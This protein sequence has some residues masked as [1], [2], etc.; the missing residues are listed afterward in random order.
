MKS[1]RSDN[2]PQQ[3]ALFIE[4]MQ[5]G[6]KYG[7][8]LD[9]KIGRERVEERVWREG[10]KRGKIEKVELFFKKLVGCK[11]DFWKL[12]S[13]D[14]AC[15]FCKEM[16]NLKFEQTCLIRSLIAGFQCSFGGV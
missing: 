15:M 16:K 11:R 6:F 2:T 4:M 5:E 12:S 1:I 9:E 8:I 10:I 14:E 13:F 3:I 7:R